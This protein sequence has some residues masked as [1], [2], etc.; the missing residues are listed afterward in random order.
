MIL[1]LLTSL[2]YHV[3]VCH[4]SVMRIACEHSEHAL[5]LVIAFIVGIYGEAYMGSCSFS[6]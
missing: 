2:W 1:K 3:L 4:N 5:I 6:T